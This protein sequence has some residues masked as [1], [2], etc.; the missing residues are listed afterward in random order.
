VNGFPAG[1]KEFGFMVIMIAGGIGC[2][3]IMKIAKPPDTTKREGSGSKGI[4]DLTNQM[5]P[6]R[7]GFKPRPSILQNP[8]NPPC[9]HLLF[10]IY[11][12]PLQKNFIC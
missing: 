12:S 3:D 11:P 6:S 10:S 7:A 1:G 5:N 8:K 4:T 9:G 2:Q